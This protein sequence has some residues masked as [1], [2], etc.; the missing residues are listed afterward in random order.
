[1]LFRSSLGELVPGYRARI[2]GDDGADL[3]DGEIGQLWVAGDSGNGYYYAH[4][5]A[6]APGIHD[7]QRVRAGELVGFV[8][9]T[10]NAR[11]TSPH[12]HFE[13]HPGGI[14]PVNPYPLLRAAYGNRPKFTAVVPTT[15]PPAPSIPEPAA[16]GG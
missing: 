9:D 8:G 7:G 2:V 12:L 11:G 4:L 10:G 3:P 1:M 5:S 13:I 14:G 6:F 16:A 15:V